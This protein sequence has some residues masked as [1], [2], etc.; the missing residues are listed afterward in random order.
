LR[1]AITVIGA[2]AEVFGVAKPGFG[3]SAIILVHEGSDYP[4]DR[5]NS[6]GRE[7]RGGQLS[8]FLERD[9]HDD[10]KQENPSS[11][12]YPNQS[13]VEFL[14]LTSVKP[15]VKPNDTSRKN[16]RQQPEPREQRKP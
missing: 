2:E 15:S 13:W 8:L 6:Q 4:G 7:D 9:D 14:N 3:A 1:R 12:H 16:D 5:A 10:D 11:A